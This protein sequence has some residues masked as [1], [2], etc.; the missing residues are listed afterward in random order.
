[1]AS[2]DDGVDYLTDL[3][4]IDTDDPDL[5]KRSTGPE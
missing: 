5:L 4:E 1:M 3:I 2:T